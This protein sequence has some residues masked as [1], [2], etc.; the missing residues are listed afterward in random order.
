MPLL[1]SDAAITLSFPMYKTPIFPIQSAVI[2][3]PIYGKGEAEFV[4]D[5]VDGTLKYDHD[6]YITDDTERY[7]Q[8]RLVGASM[9]DDPSLA[10]LLGNLIDVSDRLKHGVGYQKGFDFP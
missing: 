4:P 3:P 2:S 1:D 8:E 6:A 10:R 7:M 5:I 9:G